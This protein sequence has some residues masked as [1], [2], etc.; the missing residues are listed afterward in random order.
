MTVSVLEVD[1]DGV[2]TTP[3]IRIVGV[4]VATDADTM[5]IRNLDHD[6]LDGTVMFRE[7]DGSPIPMEIGGIDF[8]YDRAKTQLEKAEKALADNQNLSL[9]ETK[10]EDVRKAQAVYNHFAAQ[11]A[12]AED[13]LAAG[14]LVVDRMGA[15][16]DDPGGGDDSP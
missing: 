1:H 4:E 15:N 12:S 9:V 3:V 16:P 14:K 7:F 10:K 8:D 6:Q 5:A 11:K 2:D 13:D